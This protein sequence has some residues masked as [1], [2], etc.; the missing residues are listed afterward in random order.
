[1]SLVPFHIVFLYGCNV[2]HQVPDI[3]LGF[4][5]AALHSKMDHY[6]SGFNSP[7]AYRSKP[8]DN[9]MI[10][11]SIAGTCQT[12]TQADSL[13]WRQGHTAIGH[14]LA[15]AGTEAAGDLIQRVVI[16]FKFLVVFHGVHSFRLVFVCLYGENSERYILFAKNFFK[17][18][19]GCRRRYRRLF[20]L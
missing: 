17:C 19:A 18:P 7:I 2:V 1:M 4:F 9:C 14:R 16:Q 20:Y 15:I 8:S 11:R 6:Q 3:L 13:P 12:A 10:G 5:I